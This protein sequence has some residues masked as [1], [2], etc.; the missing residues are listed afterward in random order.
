[1]GRPLRVIQNIYPYHL[2]CRTNNRTFRFNQRQATRIVFKA[3]TQGSEKYEVLV[4]HVILVSN[5]YHII[6]TA[7]KENLHRF[8]QY[9]NSRIAIRYNKHVGRSGHLWG[10][11]YGSCIIDTDEYYLACVRYIYRNPLRA[12]MVE[13]LEEF[14]DSSFQFYAFGKKMDVFLAGDH[15]VMRWGKSKKRVREYFKILVLDEGAGFT[16][17]EV[18]IGLRRMFF[19]S[20]DFMQHMV[21]THCCPV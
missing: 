5:H 12:G 18:K 16:D 19:G 7:T 1:M 9:I 8:M 10:D 11:R 6:A 14:T 21:N 3:L 2:V 17:E 20:A 15:L 4:H 13:D